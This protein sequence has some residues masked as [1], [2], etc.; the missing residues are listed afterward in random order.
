MSIRSVVIY[1]NYNLSPIWKSFATYC[2]YLVFMLKCFATLSWLGQ[3]WIL[4]DSISYNTTF[5]G[6]VWTSYINFGQQSQISLQSWNCM[7]VSHMHMWKLR[8]SFI[9]NQLHIH[10]HHQ[11]LWPNLPPKPTTINQD[12]WP[13]S[14]VLSC[15]S[16]VHKRIPWTSPLNPEPSGKHPHQFHSNTINSIAY[17]QPLPSSHYFYLPGLGGWDWRWKKV[18]IKWTIW[19]LSS[20]V[21]WYLAFSF[22]LMS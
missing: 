10:L 9:L 1:A 14:L 16:Q 5:L 12:K 21:I 15:L 2:Y 11:S 22:P 6:I 3:K 19:Y 7:L 20:K 4:Y 13:L 17:S 18:W 8:H